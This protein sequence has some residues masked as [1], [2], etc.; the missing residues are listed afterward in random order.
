MRGDVPGEILDCLVAAP[1]GIDIYSIA[2]KIQVPL[3]RTKKGM[4][5]LRL[6]LGEN[7][8]IFVTCEPNGKQQPWLYKLVGGGSMVNPEEHL[9]WIS[10]RVGDSESRI[11][12]MRMS[13]QAAATDL[14]HRTVLGKKAI[15]I[16]RHLRHLEEDLQA[17]NLG[18]G[19]DLN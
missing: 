5:E 7:D 14:D 1:E 4:R 2:A 19:D 18:G 10:N 3:P 17:I 15:T 12:T 6:I 11:H 8:R 9:F 16:E 13:M